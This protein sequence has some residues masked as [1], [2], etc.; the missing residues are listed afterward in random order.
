VDIN[1]AETIT[2]NINLSCAA[3]MVYGEHSQLCVATSARQV[4]RK[5][6]LRQHVYAD[7]NTILLLKTAKMR[8][9]PSGYETVLDTSRMTERV[10]FAVINK[11]ATAEQ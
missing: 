2:T 4:S 3:A 10:G 5:L 11:L 7:N 6:T 1:T 9:D 8:Q